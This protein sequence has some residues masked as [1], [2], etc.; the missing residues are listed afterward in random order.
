M[1]RAYA[2]VTRG[3]Q[4]TSRLQP[5][6]VERLVRIATESNNVTKERQIT[7]KICAGFYQERSEVQTKWVGL[8]YFIRQKSAQKFPSSFAQIWASEGQVNF[9]GT[10]RIVPPFNQGVKAYSYLRY[11]NVTNVEAELFW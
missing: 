9:E 11:I 2:G 10:G 8:L 3:P 1:C 7:P 6:D 5:V 4:T